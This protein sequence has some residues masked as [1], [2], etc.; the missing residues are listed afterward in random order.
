MAAVAGVWRVV[1][2]AVVTNSA[3]VGDGR[4]GAMQGIV[5]IMD[6]ERGRLPVRRR[7]V[8][9]GAIRREVERCVFWIDAAIVIR[10]MASGTL[11]GCS[12]ISP[13]MT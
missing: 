10:G 4:V 2:I 7:S 12:R 3:V 13:G 11:G 5:I 1:V 9:H 8:T 6:R